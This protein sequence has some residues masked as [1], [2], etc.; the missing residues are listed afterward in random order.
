[1]T[2]FGQSS[3]DLR[4]QSFLTTP[5]TLVHHDDEFVDVYDL[6][7]KKK[8]V[9]GQAIGWSMDTVYGAFTVL[10]ETTET[11]LF[12]RNDYRKTSTVFASLSSSTTGAQTASHP[13]MLTVSA[14]GLVLTSSFTD[15]SSKGAAIAVRYTLSGDSLLAAPTF[16]VA[17][18]NISVTYGQSNS[19]PFARATNAESYSLDSGSLPAGMTLTPSGE[20]VGSPLSVG[21]YTARVKATNSSGSAQTVLYIRSAAKAP[22]APNII[23]VNYGSPVT[24]IGYVEGAKG[25]DKDVVSAHFKSPDGTAINQ[26]CL[27]GTC[28]IVNRDLRENADVPVTLKQSNESGST[29]SLNTIIVRRTVLPEPHTG[30][31]VKGGVLGAA[32]T[33]TPSANMHGIEAIAT[34]ATVTRSSDNTVVKTFATCSPE[35][36]VLDGLPAGNGYVVTLTIVT[37]IGDVSSAPSD[38]FTVSEQAPVKT[39]PKLATTDLAVLSHEDFTLPLIA[40]GTGDISFDVN[41]DDLPEGMYYDAETNSINGSVVAGVY[42]VRYTATDRNDKTEGTVTITAT[43]SSL[44]APGMLP[45]FNTYDQ[46]FSVYPVYKKRSTLVAV[47]QF[48]WTSTVTVNGTKSTMTGTCTP[49]QK[50]T[51]PNA[52]WGQDLILTLKALPTAESGDT[53]SEINTFTV[54]VPDLP[55][56]VPTG[57]LSFERMPDLGAGTAV[58]MGNIRMKPSMKFPLSLG[59]AAT[60]QVDATTGCDSINRQPILRLEGPRNGCSVDP[61]INVIQGDE[62]VATND[63]NGEVYVPIGADDDGNEIIDTYN[64]LSS[65]LNIVLEPG[66]YTIEASTFSDLFKDDSMR[67]DVSDVEYDLWLTVITTPAEAERLMKTEV[68]GTAST[69]KVDR[70]VTVVPDP[71]KNDVIPAD[72]APAKSNALPGSVDSS[73][74]TAASIASLVSLNVESGVGKLTVTPNTLGG[75]TSESVEVTA[76]PGGRKCST[77]ASV[78]CTISGLS[79]WI[80]YNLTAKVTGGQNTFAT[81]ARTTL[82]WKA[83]STVKVSSLGLSNAA[84]VM[85]LNLRKGGVRVSGSCTLN[86]ARTSITV[87]KAGSCK[88]TVQTTQKAKPKLGG[89]PLTATAVIK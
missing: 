35:S 85:G 44:P 13:P 73:G 62:T 88:V 30:V 76:M 66:D 68:V 3:N 78:S 32:V 87:R 6:V 37:A 42:V 38:P 29:E 9:S 72:L 58:L 16:P 20:L 67:E 46:K 80:S 77:S 83:G 22:G 59:A 21:Y 31:I 84:K 75:G 19:V 51:L 45:A 71:A 63:D 50:C 1:V 43:P 70:V 55:P 60:V 15:A 74:A 28:V 10:G 49:Q 47:N 82:Q 54:R 64:M 40:T 34:T 14:A 53:E 81:T 48:E 12:E 26:R 41:Y 57:K 61:F 23:G 25:S 5:N 89:A 65:R 69:E 17:E 36:C 4:Y 52:V 2:V 86:A 18:Q 7:G 33:Y 79:P 56:A 11:Y 27:N 8:L 24:L 39:G